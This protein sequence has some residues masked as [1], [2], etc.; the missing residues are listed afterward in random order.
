MDEGVGANA[1]GQRSGHFMRA[2]RCAKKCYRIDSHWRWERLVDSDNWPDLSIPVLEFSEIKFRAPGHAPTMAQTR[3]NKVRMVVMLC[4]FFHWWCVCSLGLLPATHFMMWNNRSK[5]FH[6]C[7]KVGIP[8]QILTDQG[9]PFVSGLRVDLGRIIQIHT[10]VYLLQ[11]VMRL[12]SSLPGQME[13]DLSFLF[14]IRR[15][16]QT[17]QVSLCL[18]SCAAAGPTVSSRK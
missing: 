16:P 12:K 7:L 13:L 10:S 18:S 3:N 8:E 6:L 9:S 2:W 4:H 5:L 1:L 11:I 15:V 14:A 17:P